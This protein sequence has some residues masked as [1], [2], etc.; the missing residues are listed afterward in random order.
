VQPSKPDVWTDSPTFRAMCEAVLASGNRVRF[1]ARGSSMQPNLLDGDIVTAAPLAHRKAKRGQIVLTHGAAGLRVHRVVRVTSPRDLVTRGDA[2]LENDPDLQ[3]P[4]GRV[5]AV[6]RDGREIRVAWPGATAVHAARKHATRIGR[7]IGLRMKAVASRLAIFGLLLCVYGLGGAAPAAAQTD[8]SVTITAGATTVS[9]NGTITYTITATNNGPRNAQAPVVTFAVPANT[10]FQS[11]SG[12]ANWTC[13]DPAVGGTG[14][15]TCTRN[16][17]MGNGSSSTFTLAVTVNSNVAGN[18][19]ITGTANIASTTSD[20]NT[21][22]NTASV[23]VTVNTADLSIS[24]TTSVS[25]VPTGVNFTYSETATNN[26]PN[27]VPANTLVI[28]QQTP[29]NTNFRGLVSSTNWTCTNPANAGTGPI[30]CTYNLALAPGGTTATLSFNEQVNAGTAAGTT[31]Q[32]SATVTSQTADPAPTNNTAVTTILVEPATAADLSVTMT[33]AP[34]PVFVASNLSYAIRVTNLGPQTATGVTVSDTIPAGTTLVSATWP[35]GT[36][37]GTTTLSCALGSISAGSTVTVTVVVTSPLAPGTISNTASATT[38]GTDPVSTNNSATV[39]TVVQPISCATPGKDGAGGTLTGIVNAYYPPTANAAAG[40]TS[41]TLGPAAAGGAQTAIAA[42]D[43]LLFIQM[44]DAAINSTNT[45]SYGDGIPG[46]PALG[47]TALNNSGNFEFVTATN[48]VP[49]GGGTLQFVGTGANS[50]LLNSYTQAAASG[51][52]GQRTFQVIR[53]PQ[54]TSAT[55]S[56]GV[57]A[58]P[59]NGATGGVLAVDVASQLTLG[60]TVSLDGSGFRGGGG[61]ILGGGTGANTDYVTLSTNNANGSKGEGIAG[62]PRYVVS[63]FTALTSTPTNTGVEGLPNGSYARGAP[64]NAGG[65]GTDGNPTN[66]DENSGGGA[67][68]NGGAGGLGGYGWNTF[69]VLNS[70][71]GGFGG[72]AFP[73]STGSLTLGGGGGAGTSNNGGYFVNSGTH[74]SNCGANCDGIF[75]SGAPGGGIVIIHAGSAVG[76]GTI[77]AN[78]LSALGVDQDGAGGGGAGGS[79]VVYTNAGG[80]SGLTVS[81]NGGNGGSTWPLQAPGAFPGNRHGPGGGAGGGVILLSGTPASASVSAGTNGFT[82]TAFDS[83]GATPGSAGFV[84][85]NHVI[86]ETPGTQSGAYCASADLAVTNS[87]PAVT[88]PGATIT[89]TQTVKNNGPLSAVNAVFSEAIPANTTFSSLGTIPAGWTCNTATVASTGVLTC[90]NPLIGNGATSTFTLSVV[91]GAATP[92]QTQITDVASVTSGTSDPNLANNSATV[93]TIVG[94]ANAADLVVTNTPSAPVVPAGQSYSYTQTIRNN[95]PSTANGIVLTEAIPANTT[96]ASLN[97]PAG[98][99]CNSAGGTITCNVPNLVAGGLATYQPGFTVIAGTAAGTVITDTVTASM[100]T[101]ES[102]PATNSASATITVASS[103]TQTDLLVSTSATPNPV[104]DGGTLTLT[105]SVT[106]NGPGS[107]AAGNATTLT[108]TLPANVT[109]VSLGTLTG[110]TC[111]QAAGVVTCHPSGT[112]AAGA[113]ASTTITVKVNQGVAPGT[114]LT[115]TVTVAT[116]AGND[117]VAANNT[118]SATSFVASPTQADLAIIKTASPEP[119]DQGTNLVYSLQ[120]TNNGPATAQNVVVTDPLPAEVTFTSVFTTQGTCSQTAGTV[121]C[122]LG[123]ISVGGLVLVTINVNASVFSSST[124]AINTAT[125]S[126]DTGDPDL[127]NNS[128]TAIST[129]Q[130]PT[131][132]QLVSFNAIPQAGGGVLLEWK[133][134]EE[135]RNLGFNVYRQDA[136]GSHRLNPSLIAGS[137][138]ILRGGRPQHAA[139]TYQWLDPGPASPEV[140]YWLED[141]DLSGVKSQHGPAQISSAQPAMRL[142]ASAQLLANLSRALRSTSAGSQLSRVRPAQRQAEFVSST[143]RVLWPGVSHL[144]NPE[145][146]REA[147]L[148]ISVESEGWYHISRQQLV[149]AGFDPAWGARNLQLFAEGVEQPLLILGNQVGPLGPNDA[150]E[151]YGTAI[152][153]PYSGTRVYWLVEGRG[154]GKRIAPA[155]SS[156]S[157]NA[158]PASFP[159]TLVREDRTTYFAAL[160]NSEDQDNFFGDLVTSEPVDE[161]LFVTHSAPA[162]LPVTLDVTLQ[163]GT[164]AQQHSVSVAFNGSLIGTISFADQALYKSTF[165]VDSSLL[166]DGT[167]TVTLTALNGDN[168][169][170]VVQSIALHYAH[171]YAADNDWLRMLAQSGSRLH[172]TGFSNPRIRVFDITNPQAIEQLAASVQSNGAGFSCDVVVPGSAFV[173][174]Q[175]TLVAFADTQLAQ[176]A[177]LTPH[178]PGNL[179]QRQDGADILIVTHPDFAPSLAP[180]VQLRKEQGHAVKVVTIDEVFDAFNFAERSPYALRS[181]LQFAVKNWRTP[182]QSILLV[183]DASLDPRNYLG[184]GAFDFVPTRLIDTAAMK[185]ASD[186][187]FTD[188]T[189][190]GFGTIPIGRLPVR[191]PSDAQLVISK[192]VNYERGSFAGAWNSQALVVADQNVGADFTSTANSVA[193]SLGGLLSANTILAGNFDPQVARQQIITAINQGQLLVNYTGHGSVE[194]WSFADLLDDT[195]AASLQNGNS[196]PVFFLMDCLNGLFQDVYTQSLAESLLLSS[197]GGAVAVWAS[198]GFTDA[199]PQA[200]MD[201]SL[202]DILAADPATPLGAAILRAKSQTTDRDVR[203][204]WILFGDP[205]MQLHIGSSA[206]QPA[207]SNTVRPNSRSNLRSGTAK[208]KRLY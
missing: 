98:W 146:D 145:L 142:Q 135:V 128:S 114:P 151:F 42:G 171:T 147:A 77:T 175:R 148:K 122:S 125:V 91:V 48:A 161:N 82:T 164:D 55:L 71:D 111:T 11:D 194:Q 203:R 132:V 101:P 192:I 92:N 79:V 2:G 33:A 186:D 80:L 158:E 166:H 35:F 69:T 86:T 63:T 165:S 59:W 187:W 26:G 56:S 81:A 123:N 179:T 51:T 119:V 157:G 19:V 154:P 72:A 6:E 138:L 53:V 120:I 36:C 204:T 46:D 93:V 78:G 38:T 97:T 185:T 52:Q 196:L 23:N 30:I 49:V 100:T 160:L 150:I 90:T 12:A 8:L 205:A 4:L 44:Q 143:P 127:L 18:T 67:G 10:T 84:A 181:F 89:Y 88:T 28:Y 29:A 115:N 173:G 172:I 177:S 87:G 202:I 102:N 45:S 116:T 13:V 176:P 159:Y 3:Q 60:G 153:T 95:G 24:Q 110:W 16:A 117:P 167:N 61:R 25:T 131:A 105:L 75:S 34:T 73:A 85:S 14:T 5:I 99:N 104:L 169:L 163:G 168:D 200:G 174:G 136:A 83:F 62:T 144:G 47:S 180:L 149:A 50:G 126:A 207:S 118:A 1:R 137:A 103:A 191:T 32:N 129:I 17:N 139:K 182:P 64:G 155:L 152:D 15:S 76:T 162:D 201:R 21:A 198:S 134:R 22:N 133:T 140:S 184:L 208:P 58:M 108:D 31:I 141:V 107:V 65:G 96:L 156:S 113:V 124:R 170:S 195:D 190:T 197:N 41:V 7:A 112:F 37:T 57:Q 74:N 40:A 9:P 20:P 54:Y 189:Q 94:Q 178:T 193:S 66:N 27:T 68:A 183:G 121:S 70:T 106:N 188:F 39:V 109:L 130:S 43:L 206:P 199:P